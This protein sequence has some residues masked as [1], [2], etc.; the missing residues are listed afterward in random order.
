MWLY[1]EYCEKFKVQTKKF[2]LISLVFQNIK[3]E[4]YG[5]DRLNKWTENGVSGNK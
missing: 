5:S 1:C 4:I 2:Y 3:T